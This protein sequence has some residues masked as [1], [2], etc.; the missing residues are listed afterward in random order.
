MSDEAQF[1]NDIE[2]LIEPGAQRGSHRDRIEFWYNAKGDYIE[3]QT[4]DE[5]VVADRID[6][7]LTIYRSLEKR[8]AIGF[9]IKGVKALMNIAGGEAVEVTASH[10]G[11]AVISVR[12]LLLK[13]LTADAATFRRTR[14]YADAIPTLAKVE[15]D[16]VAITR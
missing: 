11:K 15:D 2:Q 6:D 3:F 14:G 9:K 16:H 13:A 10:E 8:E 1:F 4:V 5:A 7:Y 12:V